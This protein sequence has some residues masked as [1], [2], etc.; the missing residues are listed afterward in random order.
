[1]ATSDLGKKAKTSILYN[2]AAKGASTFGQLISTVFLARLLVPEDFGIV[3]TSM[4]VIGFATKFGEFGFHQ[5]LIQRKEAITATHINTLFTID[6]AFKSVLWLAIFF[7]SPRLAIYFDEPILAQA[8][9]I[10]SIYILLECFS[11]TPLTV[12]KRDVDFKSVSIN[13]TIEM[14]TTIVLS[15]VLAFLG[16]GLWSLVYSKLAGITIAGIL[17][18]QKTHWL[19]KLTFNRQAGRDLFHFGVMIFIRNLF[20]YGADNIDYFF[21]SKYLGVQTLG[22][23][24]KAFILMRMPQKR[25][26]RS[27]NRVIFSA[28]SRIQD[29]PERIRKIF[30]KLVLAVSLLTYPLLTG[31]ALVAY[32]FIAVV[33][34]EKWLG[35][36]LPLQIMC[37]A[38]IL[39]SIDPFL[40]STL[41]ATGYVRSTVTRRAL[42]FFLLAVTTFLGVQFGLAGVA[43]AVGFS[44]VIV[45][46]VMMNM[47]TRVT[48][49]QW[50]DYFYPQMP[51]IVTSLCMM[52]AMFLIRMVLA[53]RVDPLGPVMLVSMVAIGG[54]VYLGLHLLFRFKIVIELV[55]ELRGDT[56]NVA[57]AL[58]KKIS[59]SKRKSK[60]AVAADSD[61]RGD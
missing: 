24:E 20:R 61:R 55:E 3:T 41:T 26:T 33:L 54:M 10:L 29:D 12:L 14:F 17:A 59:R 44:A 21:V 15:I 39:R 9:P 52:A 2:I 49:I 48:K 36:A 46:I 8:L 35:A 31:L 6:F 13:E 37:I 51:A 27:V 19:P 50:R 28:F 18:I 38:G 60:L 56:K 1:M 25:I 34:G 23:Y 11:T 42:E 30:R 32:P 45:M 57:G 5:G 58:K 16:F 40:N 47:I 22:L 4:L 53:S 43:T 7:F